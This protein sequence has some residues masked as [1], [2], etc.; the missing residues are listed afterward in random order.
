MKKNMEDPLQKW[1]NE[2]LVV[3]TVGGDK[4]QEENLRQQLKEKVREKLIGPKKELKT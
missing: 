3:Y 2:N 4:K 1:L